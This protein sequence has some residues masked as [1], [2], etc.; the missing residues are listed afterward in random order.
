MHNIPFFVY[1]TRDSNRGFVILRTCIV[2]NVYQHF[3]FI[4]YIAI[5]FT[6]QT[7]SDVYPLS[8]LLFLAACLARHFD[9]LCALL[10]I[11]SIDRL[12]GKVFPEE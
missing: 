6:R 4:I 3:T 2:T 12:Y 9:T 8:A 1:P 10:S 7:F 5:S 11:I